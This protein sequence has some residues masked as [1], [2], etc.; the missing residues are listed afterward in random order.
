[1]YVVDVI[2]NLQET[3]DTLTSNVVFV[4]ID[5]SRAMASPPDPL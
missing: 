3:N 2:N 5:F 1:M 4:T